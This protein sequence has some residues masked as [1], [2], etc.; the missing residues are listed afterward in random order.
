MRP[1]WQRTTRR[2]A[3]AHPVDV[4]AFLSL[5]VI[6]VPFLLITAV[7]SRTAILE[8]QPAGGAAVHESAADALQLQ[9]VVRR[10]WIE[11]NYFGLAQPV[12]IER[13]DDAAALASLAA[14][15]GELKARYPQS[16]EATV[17]L[18]PQISYELLIQV[19]DALR[20]RLQPMADELQQEAL[21]PLIALGPVA[22]SGQGE[23]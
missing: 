6:L 18:E 20:I 8:L 4:T 19:L 2:D 3:H 16:Q 5:M 13:R 21:F 7:F 12:R 14:L 23:P 17:L 22:S 15:A 10:A 9:V 1:R 11:V